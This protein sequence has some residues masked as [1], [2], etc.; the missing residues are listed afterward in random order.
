MRLAEEEGENGGV[1]DSTG[2]SLFVGE[3]DSVGTGVS[4]GT[5]DM[6]SVGC[7][8]RD[9]GTDWDSVDVGDIETVG[10]LVRQ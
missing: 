10:I 1:S 6:D 9:F 5:G 7:G 4:D 3:L 2:E 8:E